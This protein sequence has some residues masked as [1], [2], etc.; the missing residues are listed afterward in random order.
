MKSLST[1][2]FFITLVLVVTTCREDPPKPPQRAEC[3]KGFLP[4]EEDSTICCEVLCPP[5]HLLGGPDSTECIPVEC[6]EFYHLCGV[7]STEC[8]LDTTSHEMVWEVDTIL[9]FREPWTKYRIYDVAIVDENTIWAVGDFV[10]PDPSD[11]LTNFERSFNLAEWKGVGWKLKKIMESGW[12]SIA[13][14][15]AIFAL[16]INEVWVGN[17][18]IPMYWNGND[19]QLRA[20]D[21]GWE[22]F[23]AQINAIWA[24]SS[25]DVFFISNGGQINHWNGSGFSR[26]ETPTETR[27]TD[28]WGTGHDNVWVVGFD[29]QTAKTALLHYDG[30][31]WVNLYEGD[32]YDWFGRKE[33][34]LSGVIKS[35]YTHDPNSIKVLSN[36]NGIYTTTSTLAPAAQLRPLDFDWQGLRK[37]RGNHSNDL[38]VCGNHSGIVHY[39]GSTQYK[40]VLP[41]DFD[42]KAIDVQG[43][44]V[45]TVGYD[46]ELGAAIAC[47][48]KR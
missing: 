16:S 23:G 40:Y 43:D 15:E 19:W 12:S 1:I 35:V 21:Y 28:I 9:A 32:I 4:C 48:G 17:Y 24:S 38:F 47:I 22:L 26:M 18:E 37:L 27:L 8:C 45:V 34:A 14:A 3:D 30:T 29:T 46:Y 42:F 20:T 33:D 5:G 31:A 39:N 41:G 44:L 6:P 25:D 10:I 11:T 7:D 36:P 13:R 2:L